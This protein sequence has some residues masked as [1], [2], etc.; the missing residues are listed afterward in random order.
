MKMMSGMA[1]MFAFGSC[2]RLVF[3]FELVV[4]NFGL[5]SVV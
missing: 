3:S 2:C 5:Q 1:G 4:K